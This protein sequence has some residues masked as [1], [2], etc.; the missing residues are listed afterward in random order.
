M[1]QAVRGLDRLKDLDRLLTEHA[2]AAAPT[3][4]TTTKPTLA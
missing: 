1:R 2:S 4:P 3:E